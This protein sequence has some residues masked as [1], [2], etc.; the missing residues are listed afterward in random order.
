MR[1]WQVA[2][3]SLKMRQSIA[4]RL[5]DIDGPPSVLPATT[6]PA[7]ETKEG[8]LIEQHGDWNWEDAQLRLQQAYERDGFSGWFL[9]AVREMEAERKTDRKR[10]KSP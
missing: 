2:E 6:P 8:D 7:G 10:L 9:G 4:R 1:H 5:P 3:F